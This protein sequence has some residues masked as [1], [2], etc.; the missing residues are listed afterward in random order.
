MKHFQAWWPEFRVGKTIRFFTSRAPLNASTTGKPLWSWSGL[1]SFQHSSLEPI[2]KPCHRVS[3]SVASMHRR[4]S[5]FM[6]HAFPWP[7]WNGFHGDA[8]SAR[9]CRNKAP[10]VVKSPGAIAE[11]WPC[12]TLWGWEPW[13]WRPRRGPAASYPCNQRV[14]PANSFTACLLWRWYRQLC[15]P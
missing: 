6:D 13:M 4:L 12:S 14:T 15:R 8:V 2:R 5:F 9:K 3:G 10:A 1:L 11:P 7:P